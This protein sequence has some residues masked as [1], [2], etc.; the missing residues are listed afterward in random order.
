MLA[1]A[2]TAA[3]LLAM[4]AAAAAKKPRITSAYTKLNW[5]KCKT[6][7]SGD[8]EGLDWELR[9]CTGY[10]HNP[11]FWA[12]D[13][14]RDDLDAGVEN[15]AGFLEGPMH[16]LGNVVEWRLADGRPFAIIYRAETSPY[17]G[18]WPN[19]RWSRLIVE[20]VGRPGKP[21]CP[22]AKFDAL[23]RNANVAARKAADAVLSG[24]THCIEFDE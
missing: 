19:G 24:N 18:E 23:K 2:L 3:L 6:V 21:G 5:D 4:P 1:R 17:N 9:R 22:I 16:H 15:Q 10:A 13:D 8:Q 7:R 14:E 20:T 11:I 12:Y